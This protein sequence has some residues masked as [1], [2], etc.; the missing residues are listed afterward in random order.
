MTPDPWEMELE[1]CYGT[2]DQRH[3]QLRDELQA[4][5]AE[6]RS[7]HIHVDVRGK[8]AVTGLLRPSLLLA[9]CLLVSAIWLLVV[10]MGAPRHAY[11]LED[12]PQLL[13]GVRSI[14]IR[15][16]NYFPRS[17][18]KGIKAPATPFESYIERPRRYRRTYADNPAAG[19]RQMHI[20]SDGQRH[21]VINDLD[22]TVV[23]GKE[24][25]LAA[26]YAVEDMIQNS[27]VQK[28]LGGPT[29]AG[30]SRIRS[31]QLSGVTTDVYERKFQYPERPDRSRILVW[32][33]PTTGFPLQAQHFSRWQDEPERMVSLC[34][35]IEINVE[36]PAGA[37][38][39]TSPV[40]YTIEHRNETSDKI[41]STMS[42]SLG[43]PGRQAFH[44]LR[45]CFNIDGRAA[46]ICWAR[47]NDLGKPRERDLEGP[48]GR[49]L[50]IAPTS[51]LGDR[52]YAN[53]FLRI[54]PGKDFHWRWSLIVPEGEQH[55]LGEGQ[56]VFTFVEADGIL[57]RG[58]LFGTP[59][60]F[61][62]E[63]LAK[64][65]LDAQR[66]T[67]QPDAPADTIFTIERIEELIEKFRKHKG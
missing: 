67:L 43:E 14:H 35:K 17:T 29:A 16:T 48:V 32:L 38:D 55:T 63:Q 57:T 56:L 10:P 25:P 31:E 20:A 54:D 60:R 12:L 62:R 49:S 5:L 28:L 50:E 33:N 41:G 65:I 37:F 27:L 15:G 45:F 39:F 64:W 36:P 2:F 21:I 34:D 24:A 18:D 51:S 4:R 26:E 13:L 53:Y 3:A 6:K 66:L 1:R 61:E 44:A 19:V 7:R 22:K 40:G 58:T 59:L 23:E 30:F 52:T 8:V 46:L 11:G 47:F 9:G 42:G